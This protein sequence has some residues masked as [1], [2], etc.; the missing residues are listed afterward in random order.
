MAKAG[1]MDQQITFRRLTRVSDGGGGVVETWA[2]VPTNPTVWAKVTFKRGREGLEEG[3]INASQMTAFEVYNRSD[4]TEIDGILWGGEFYNI[5][6]VRRYGNRP[7]VMWLD[8]ERGV[9]N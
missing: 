2:D 9:A 7:L 5:R 1:A 4:I 6:T 8:A 3:R